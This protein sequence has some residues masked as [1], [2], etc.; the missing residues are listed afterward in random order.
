[1]IELCIHLLYS[2]ALHEEGLF[3]IPGSSVKI[4][5]LKNAINAWF[6]TLASQTELESDQHE[7]LV[8]GSQ[9]PSLLAIYALF[10]DIVSQKKPSET[11]TSVVENSVTAINQSAITTPTATIGREDSTL[12]HTNLQST[13]LSSYSQ[14][15]SQQQQFLVFD[16]HTI[17]GLLK[18]YL[19]E[20]KEPLFT[21]ALY[22]Q[23]IDATVKTLNPSTALTATQS[24]S[25]EPTPSVQSSSIT[26]K[27]LEQVVEQ[28][29][30]ANYDNLRLL[31]R[32]LHILTCH[33]EFN[34]MTATNLAITMAP[35]LI[36]SKPAQSVQPPPTG[37]EDNNSTCGV[38][39][40]QTQMDEMH[41]LNMQ[42]SSVGISASL[43]ALVIENLISHAEI[44]FP[45]QMCF[46]LPGLD[47]QIPTTTTSTN[48]VVLGGDD[49]KVVLSKLA[50]SAQGR[51]IKS[52]SPTGLSTASSS[53]FSS[54]TSVTSSSATTTNKIKHSRK[55]GSMDGLLNDVNTNT[56]SITLENSNTNNRPMSVHLN[57]QQHSSFQPKQFQQQQPPPVPPAP[58]A[59]S[60]SRQASESSTSSCTV[61]NRSPGGG[62]KQLAPVPPPCALKRQPKITASSDQLSDYR[63]RAQSKQQQAA[64]PV[65]GTSLRGT[66]IIAPPPPQAA[67]RPNVPPPNRPKLGKERATS[68]SFEALDNDTQ[69]SENT[70]SSSNKMIA[71][72]ATKFV[73]DSENN[74]NQGDN[75]SSDSV[76]SSGNLRADFEEI[77]A[78]D[79]DD[80]DS[81]APISPI[82]SLG[83]ISG[84]DGD[85][86]FDDD[87]PSLEHSWTECELGRDGERNQA[88]G[89][90]KNS[91]EPKIVV[92][93]SANDEDSRCET[94]R[95]QIKP[96]PRK[97]NNLVNDGNT[98][99]GIAEVEI[100][101]SVDRDDDEEET[102]TAPPIK[103]SRSTSPKVTQSTPL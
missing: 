84:G 92:V 37:Q 34:R 93:S 33:Q 28:L 38:V 6:V 65:I 42:M 39:G 55:G 97:R 67:T 36:W 7:Q 74:L 71:V 18:L 91:G 54:T 66:G 78:A 16:V 90:R 98:K 20:L 73:T 12:T 46:T 102:L 57:Q 103:P 51:C 69:Q 14:E 30:K 23:W 25:S 62:H 44:L 83:S 96:V 82:I 22:D 19:R 70:S 86:S 31:I 95:G 101:T 89:M 3:R 68:S 45:G 9:S 61:T 81:S 10:K 43:H 8:V 2:N 87:C 24:N 41:A 75:K 47:E 52:T 4:K 79:V 72:A 32:F 5:K 94:L 59:R 76:T 1:M 27:A 53:S 35:S 64:P 60:H 49:Q 13:I 80:I 56:A 85:S 48:K 17:A 100:S 26:L 99:N 50:A 29:P 88:R 11:T 15:P 58:A 40:E 21:Y 77:N 63:A